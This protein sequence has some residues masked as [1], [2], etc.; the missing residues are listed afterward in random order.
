MHGTEKRGQTVA[1]KVPTELRGNW[2]QSRS[3]R[4]SVT[5]I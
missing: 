5:A 1:K 3:P 2:Q 4:S